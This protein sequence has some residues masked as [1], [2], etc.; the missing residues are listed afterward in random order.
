MLST[1]SEKKS[2]SL[3]VFRLN[4]V[5]NRNGVIYFPKIVDVAFIP[6]TFKSQLGMGVKITSN[7]IVNP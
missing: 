2:K 4:L 1:G 6:P 5:Y 3:L 7:R